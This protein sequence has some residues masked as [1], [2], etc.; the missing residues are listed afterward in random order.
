MIKLT[1]SRSRQKYVESAL[2]PNEALAID[3]LNEYRNV[4]KKE[5]DLGYKGLYG[6]FSDKVSVKLKIL[7]KDG[8]NE[9]VTGTISHYDDNFSQL[10]IRTGHSLKRFTF[11]QIIDAQNSSGGLLDERPTV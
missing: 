6:A 8:D 10:V 7:N 3:D 4:Y 11:D 2:K 9:E 1:K 5:R